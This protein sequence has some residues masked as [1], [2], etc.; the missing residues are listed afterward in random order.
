[1]LPQQVRHRGRNL[2]EYIKMFSLSAEDLHKSIVDC[3]S[4]PS[5]F[6]CDMTKFRR[7][8]VSVDPLYALSK[9]EVEQ[10]INETHRITSEELNKA[11]E[12]CGVDV[13]NAFNDLWNIHISAMNVFLAD[14]E[15]GKDEL[16][17]VPA[18]LPILGFGSGQFHLALCA[19]F[20][21]TYTH[22]LTFKFHLES[23]REMVRVANEARIY[24]VFDLNGRQSDHL[25]GIIE[26]LS[27]DNYMVQLQRV[28]HELQKGA[29]Q[30]LV[31]KTAGD[32]FGSK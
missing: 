12:E 2:Y 18:E 20:L 31:V 22:L 16:R 23:I 8:V 3:A 29:N 19:H 17:Y 21:F 30:M 15:K 1:M 25:D 4:G 7:H 5:S 13:F 10:K 9:S 14:Y 11:R 6:N 27:K 26:T 24:P 28:D 32:G